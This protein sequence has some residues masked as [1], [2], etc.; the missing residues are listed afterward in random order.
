MH[1][2]PQQKREKRAI[3]EIQERQA[4][5]Q[6]AHASVQVS[7]TPTEGDDDDPRQIWIVP[8][9]SPNHDEVKSI[10]DRVRSVLPE[11]DVDGAVDGRDEMTEDR[12]M[13]LLLGT[14]VEEMRRQRESED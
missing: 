2:T 11:Y 1:D 4:R 6:T 8:E 9:G 14:S 7:V 12:I 13:A 5:S 10:V 3:Q